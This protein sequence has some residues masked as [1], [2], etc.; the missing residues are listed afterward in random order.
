MLDRWDPPR[1]LQVSINCAHSEMAYGFLLESNPTEG[2]L[3]ISIELERSLVG[4]PRF[5]K[6]FFN[7]RLQRLGKE[8]LSNLVIRIQ[9][10]K[11]LQG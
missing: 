2:Q 11:S 7:W 1:N 8:T 3:R 9:L 4:L 5:A 10:T 6:F